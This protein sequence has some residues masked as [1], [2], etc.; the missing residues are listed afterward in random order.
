MIEDFMRTA[1]DGLRLGCRRCAQH[2]ARAVNPPS[3]ELARLLYA[4]ARA[5]RMARS[6]CGPQSRSLR[7]PLMKCEQRMGT[8]VHKFWAKCA[9]AC[10]HCQRGN[11]TLA[12]FYC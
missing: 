5:F 8:R 11:L 3:A 4:S 7:A 2:C 10:D 6:I 9:P 12:Q 1:P